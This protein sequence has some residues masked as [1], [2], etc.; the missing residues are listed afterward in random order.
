MNMIIVNTMVDVIILGFYDSKVEIRTLSKDMQMN[1]FTSC[2]EMDI[3]NYYIWECTL[4]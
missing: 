3:L 4:E 2:E 1:W